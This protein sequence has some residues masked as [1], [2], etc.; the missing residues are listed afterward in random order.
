MFGHQALYPLSHSLSFTVP[1]DHCF[2]RQLTTLSAR[3]GK[4]LAIFTIPLLFILSSQLITKGCLF[5]CYV[6]QAGVTLMAIF[7]PHPPHPGR[8]SMCQ[9]AWLHH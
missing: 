4:E 5:I 8:T 7:L 2:Q 3:A 6:L 9:G 1:L